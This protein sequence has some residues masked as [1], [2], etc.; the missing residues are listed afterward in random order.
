MLATTISYTYSFIVLLAAI[1]LQH[2]P[3]PMT[4]FDTPPMLLMFVS[5]GRWLEHIAKVG[6]KK[7]Y[8]NSVN[9]C[10]RFTL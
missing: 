1:I 2:D 9:E 10:F 6:R 3:S 8:K 5:L 7:Y 4:F